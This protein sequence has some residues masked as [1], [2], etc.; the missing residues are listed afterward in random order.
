[1]VNKLLG[2]SG[3]AMSK[4]RLLILALTLTAVAAVFALAAPLVKRKVQSAGCS[5]TMGAICC[6]ARIWAGDGDGHFPSDFLSM[7]N[8]LNTPKVL[9]CPGDHSRQPAA[10]WATFTPADSSYEIVTPGLHDSDTNNVFVRCKI[11]GHLGY[12]DCAVLD[13]ANRRRKIP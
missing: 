4:R 12:A 1:M 13:E 10:S 9:I 7:S 3:H 6:A 8:E 5:N 2:R 11:H